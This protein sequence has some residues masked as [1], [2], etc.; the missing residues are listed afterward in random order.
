MSNDE[1]ARRKRLGQYFT[2]QKLAH[3]LAQLALA[4][5][6]ETII[7]PMAGAGVMLAACRMAGAHSSLRSAIELDPRAMEQLSTNPELADVKTHTGSAFDASCFKGLGWEWDLVISNPPYVRYQSSSKINLG[8]VVIPS[9]LEVRAGL[10]AAVSANPCLDAHAKEVLSRATNYS[11]QSDL[12]VPAWIL[13]AMLVKPGGR[14]ALVVPDTW[15]SRDYATPVIDVLLELFDVEVVVEDVNATWFPEASVRTN[16]I[17]GRRRSGRA[18]P[19]LRSYKHVRIAASAEDERSLVGQCFKGQTNPDRAFTEWLRT[20]V[21]PVRNLPEGVTVE[22]RYEFGAPHAARG[23]DLD[24]DAADLS[25]AVRSLVGREIQCVSLSS[26]GWEVGQGLRTGANEFFYVRQGVDGS[27]RST[28]TGDRDLSIDSTFLRKAIRRQSEITMV[29]GRAQLPRTLDNW[30][31]IYIEGDL[32]QDTSGDL[33]HLIKQAESTHHDGPGG[34]TIPELSAVR[35]NIR[36][37]DVGRGVAPRSWY[38]L[39]SLA[40]RHTPELFVPRV[41]GGKPLFYRN[42]NPKRVVDANF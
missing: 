24:G 34:L 15:L 4:D 42:S 35:V 27:V 1:K 23:R 33:K 13:S 6:A 29:G 32:S 22:V 28:I 17:V 31:L 7:D 16:L 8:G 10:R 14:L 12:A 30:R 41:N 40:P 38:E 18:A 37:G 20:E 21:S 36:K 5:S 26:L 25:E 2:P 9:S 19:R 11:G 39:P 3:L